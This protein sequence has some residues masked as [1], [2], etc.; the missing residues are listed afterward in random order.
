MA[1][2][3]G[4][5]SRMV[6]D[7]HGGPPSAETLYAA[8]DSTWP[9]A[10]IDHRDGWTI[11]AGAGGGKRVSAATRDIPAADPA[12]A[13]AAMRALDQAPLFM[14][15]PGEDDLDA[16][17][18]ARGYAIVDPVTLYA[19]PAAALAGR[20]PT[21]GIAL[22]DLP[23]ALMA[24]L[25]ASAGIGPARL[26]VMARVQGPRAYLLARADH[27]PAGVA[28]AA[29]AGDIAMI[30]AIEVLPG[31]RRAGIGRKLLAAAAT[32]AAA[33]G[34]GTLALAVTD[35]NTAA[36]RLYRAMGM[37]PAG[38]YHYRQARP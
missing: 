36:N 25:W 23:L 15:R 5:S 19:A 6:M 4:Q 1:P 12:R 33:E 7:L 37:A 14:I 24:E 29:R 8:I 17:L 38:R 28:F 9:P 30:H 26:A 13:E 22:G 32:W 16:D 2:P 34:A 21:S 11:R 18:A 20:A 31:H 27:A 35:A 10:R 3:L